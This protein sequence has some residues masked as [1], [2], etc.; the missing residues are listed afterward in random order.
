[1]LPPDA[2]DLSLNEVETLAQKAARGAGLPWGVA[3][4][5]GRAAAWMAR[6]IGQWA[7]PLLTLLE[8]PPAPSPLL[9][10]G[11][12]ADGAGAC[13]VGW[14]VAPLWA[15]PGLLATTSRPVSIR[16]DDAEIRCNPGEEPTATLAT[17]TLAALS[18]AALSLR[19]QSA[20][21]PLLAYALA[22]RFR[23]SPVPAAEFR[24][25]EALAYRTYVAASDHSRL[26]GAGAGL[27]DDE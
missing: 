4:D 13:D 12:L 3:E 14:L 5:T 27:L 9:L 25:L 21:L 8:T 10:A 11:M 23:R 24:R 17:E 1:M 19:F 7:G 2:L 22:K 16:L 26:T 20:T 18:A 15:L 6:R